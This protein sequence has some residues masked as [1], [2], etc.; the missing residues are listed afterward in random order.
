MS[1]KTK[2]L[3]AALATLLFL[4]S[5]GEA[6]NV[7]LN[8]LQTIFLACRHVGGPTQADDLKAYAEK[9]GWSNAE[10]AGQLMAFVKAG[11]SDDADHFQRRMGGGAL[12]GLAQFGGEEEWAF[13][14]DI[15]TTSDNQ[16]FREVAIQVSIRMMPE[17]WEEVVREVATNPRFGSYDRFLACES[18]FLAGKDRSK[19]E[20]VRMADVFAELAEQES[21]NGNRGRLVGWMNE[22]K[23]Q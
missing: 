20:R 2:Y 9:N 10:M 1:K 23:M 13:V 18:A 21:S 22:L 16:H 6:E 12:Y 7:G 15:M 14:W 5:F 3:F 11:L 17:K 4:V 8:P 19:D